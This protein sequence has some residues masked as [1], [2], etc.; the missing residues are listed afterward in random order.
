MASESPAQS[1][2]LQL[3]NVTKTYREGDAERAVLRDLSLSLARGKTAVLMG[4]SGAGK[5]TLLN[6]ISGI[7]L[8]TSGRISIDGTELTE[9]S[10]TDRTLFRRSNIGF[11]FQSFNLISTLT[12][13][14]NVLLP[15]ELAG[16][17]S[18][19]ARQRAEEILGRVGLADR[20]DSFPDR[21]SGGEQQR[22]AVARALAHNPL[23]VLADEPTGNLDYETGQQV[24]ALLDE[25]VRETD[26]TL[27][28]ATHD[29]EAL[30]RADRLLHLRGG[31]LHEGEPDFLTTSA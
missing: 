7:D 14:E 16:E 17:T 27:L 13:V 3:T 23:F 5:S 31:V 4:R 6:L 8:P 24:L 26:T 21:L 28:I 9:L 15:L 2:L 11:V 25:L 29:R 10:E 22:V 18:D 19:D 20:T 30:D 12:V 1:P